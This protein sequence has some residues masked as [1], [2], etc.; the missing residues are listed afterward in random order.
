MM[1]HVDDYDYDDEDCEYECDKCGK[2]LDWIPKRC[3]DGLV[4]RLWFC[5]CGNS[6]VEALTG[7]E[8]EEKL[9]EIFGDLDD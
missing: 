9:Q 7:G 8:M 3:E 5:E 4:R 6:Y 1:G 2:C